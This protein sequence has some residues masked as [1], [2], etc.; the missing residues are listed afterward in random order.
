MSIVRLYR[1]YFIDFRK[2]KGFTGAMQRWG[3]SGLPASHGCS[4]AH[5]SIGSTGMR[6]VYNKI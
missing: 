3:F 5:R 6:A 1:F 4:K 2:G